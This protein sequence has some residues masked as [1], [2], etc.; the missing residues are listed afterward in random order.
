MLTCLSRAQPIAGPSHLLLSPRRTAQEQ[1]NHRIGQ[2]ASRDSNSTG[3]EKG[4]GAYPAQRWAQSAR[5]RG[6][7]SHTHIDVEFRPTI[8]AAP[9]RTHFGKGPPDRTAVDATG[10][11]TPTYPIV[12][13]V[14]PS[15]RRP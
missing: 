11:L 10:W 2:T 4:G 8:R 6:H 14:A 5:P 13:H 7:R 15:R 12:R 9:L 3:L 1:E